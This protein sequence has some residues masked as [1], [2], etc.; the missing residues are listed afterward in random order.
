MGLRFNPSGM[1][2]MPHGR[3]PYRR[4]DEHPPYH[5]GYRE[6]HNDSEGGYT[7]LHHALDEYL[8][9]KGV[10]FDIAMVTEHVQQTTYDSSAGPTAVTRS[11]TTTNTYVRFITHRHARV[12]ILATPKMIGEVLIPEIVHIAFEHQSKVH[13]IYRE[14]HKQP[15]FIEL[16]VRKL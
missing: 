8:D 6:L 9:D 16:E 13:E 3:E 4:V 1:M 11:P 14:F 5:N 10:D 12:W 15:T 7:P 2:P